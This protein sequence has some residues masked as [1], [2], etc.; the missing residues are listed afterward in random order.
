[1]KALDGLPIRQAELGDVNGDGRLDALIGTGE[2]AQ[3]W[4]NQGG[5]ASGPNFAPSEQAFAARQTLGD[6]LGA[7]YSGLAKRA[8]GW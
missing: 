4:L 6:R 8:L 1:M 5:G 2:G 3:L 7:G